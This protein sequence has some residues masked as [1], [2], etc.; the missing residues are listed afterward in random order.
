MT[1]VAAVKKK[2]PGKAVKLFLGNYFMTS[3]YETLTSLNLLGEAANSMH[4]NANK[5]C[6]HSISIFVN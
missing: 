6:I 2:S 1:K 3:I 4:K 5:P